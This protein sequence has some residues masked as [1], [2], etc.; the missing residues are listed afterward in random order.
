MRFPLLSE[1]E[2][3]DQPPGETEQELA[4]VEDHETVAAVLYAMLHDARPLQRM[5]AVG[6]GEAAMT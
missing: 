6:G 3:P 4:F 5:F 1:P 2:V